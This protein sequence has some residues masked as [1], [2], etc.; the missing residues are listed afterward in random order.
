MTLLYQNDLEFY[1]ANGVFTGIDEAGRGALAGPV[2]VAAVVLDY[3][4][5][6]EGINDSKLLTPKKRAQLYPLIV[7]NALDYSI[8]E[9]SPAYID[10]FNILQATLLGFKTAFFQLASK[11][12]YCLIDGKDIHADLKHCAQAVIKGDQLFAS[13]AAASILAKVHR[14]NLMLAYDDLYPEYGFASHKGYGTAYHA[15]M[16]HRFGL[17]PIHR[18]SFKIPEVRDREVKKL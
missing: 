8:V 2:V 6:I 12:Q 14:D 17:S 3:E 18:K 7:E 16:I 10:E 11:P 9:I 1:K 15:K 4:K 5:M 13:I